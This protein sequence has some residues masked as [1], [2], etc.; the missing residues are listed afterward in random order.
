[1]RGTI[2]Y[3]VHSLQL[4]TAAVKLPVSL[5]EVKSRLEIADTDDT[6]EADLMGQIRSAT[7]YIERYI[8]R[9]LVD[10]TWTMFMD[11]F[12]GK[13]LAWWDGVRQLADTELTDLTETIAVPR[14]PLDSVTHV[15]AHLEDGTTTTVLST[16]YLVD[17]ASE[18][19]RIALLQ[20]K[21][22]PTGSLRS[23]NG[24]EVEFI[25]GY[26]PVGSDTPEPIREAVMAFVAEMNSNVGGEALKFEKVGDSSLSRFGP[27]ESGSIIPRRVRNLLSNYKVWMV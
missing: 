3:P 23:I 24:V 25:A 2:R 4:K 8:R 19:G 10:T 11:R 13:Q 12:P 9:S 17:L 26:G 14:P 18:P 27:D 20:T 21:S 1:M 6:E 22:W 5:Q 15:K 16:D 7:V